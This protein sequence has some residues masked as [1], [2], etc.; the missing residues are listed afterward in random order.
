M[1]RYGPIAERFPVNRKT[2]ILWRSRFSEKRLEPKSVGQRI[3]FRDVFW[4]VYKG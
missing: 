4:K 2:V 3:K 1:P